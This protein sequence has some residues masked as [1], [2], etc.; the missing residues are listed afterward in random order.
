MCRNLTAG[1]QALS[2]EQVPYSRKGIEVGNWGSVKA[3]G[4]QFRYP[5]ALSCKPAVALRFRQD[6]HMRNEAVDL[7]PGALDVWCVKAPFF[8]FADGVEFTVL[9]RPDL[10]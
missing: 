8:T 6:C 2:T 9:G 4:Y 10:F 3:R 7:F 1:I 5:R